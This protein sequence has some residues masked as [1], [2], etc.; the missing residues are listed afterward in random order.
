MISKNLKRKSPAEQALYC[1]VSLIFAVVAASY[2]YI[3]VWTFLS[4]LKTHTEIVLNPFSLPETPIW[5]HYLEI[6]E[7]FTVNGH[8]FLEMLFNS[9]WFSIVGAF[10]QQYTVVRFAYACTKYR[11]PGADLVY[12]IILIMMTLPLY[13][14]AGATYKIIHNFGL[15]NSYAHVL[16]SMSGFTSGFLYYR[17]YIQGISSTY[18]EAAKMDGANDFQTFRMVMFPQI[19]PL[20]TAMFLTTWLASWNNYENA[21]IYL[22]DL[23]TLPVGIYQFNKEMIFRVRLDLLFAACFVVSVPALILYIVFNKTLTTSV[24]VGGIKG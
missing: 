4:S 9:V 3:I 22:A 1:F 7:V 8:G 23:P 10:L 12:T 18:M 13:G 15:T 17:A 21:L 6:A 24:S 11:F 19:K 20:F 16:I 2:V 14:S 5:S